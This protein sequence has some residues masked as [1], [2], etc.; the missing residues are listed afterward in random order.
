M[1]VAH[2]RLDHAT[3][4]LTGFTRLYAEDRYGFLCESLGEAGRNRFSFFGGRPTL[5]HRSWP[6]RITIEDLDFYNPPGNGV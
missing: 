2:L 4:A 5:V 6:T 3:K 1:R